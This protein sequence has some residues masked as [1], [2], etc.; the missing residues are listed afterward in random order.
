[1]VPPAGLMAVVQLA[2]EVAT[3][4]ALRFA[5]AELRTAAKQACWSPERAAARKVAMAAGRPAWVP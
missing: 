5:E 2:L 3:A 4:A 1:M